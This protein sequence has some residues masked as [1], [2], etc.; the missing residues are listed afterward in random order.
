METAPPQPRPCAIA[1][2]LEVIGERWSLL[3]VRE[4]FWGNHRFSDIQ[5]ATGAPRDIL[6]AR[7]RRL[8][9]AGIL[10]KRAYSERPPRAEYHLTPAGRA[11][12]PVLMTIQEWAYA[13][14]DDEAGTM[15]FP[16]GDHDTDPVSS[17]ACRVC[18]KPLSK[19]GGATRPHT[20]THD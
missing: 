19:G 1:D 10:E 9:D 15:R 13:H 5:R 17:F 8:V 20:H 4:Q 14:L 2:A 16:H 18:G 3:I 6:A 12:S 7:L 11:L